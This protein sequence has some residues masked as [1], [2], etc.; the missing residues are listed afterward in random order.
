MS[1]RALGFVAVSGVAAAC[2]FGSRIAF[3]LY[4]PYAVAVV[5]A[6]IVGLT[7]AFWL[8]RRFVFRSEGPLL[9]QFGLFFAINLVALLQTVVISLV[10]LHWL[11]PL[12]EWQW[13]A[14][15]VAHAA[16]I[17]APILTSYFGHKHVTFRAS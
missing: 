2:N 8:N 14:A 11:L 7:T 16:G 1:R 9:R 10:M 15:E 6:F 17:I 3:S 13:H 4:A 5:L 12:M